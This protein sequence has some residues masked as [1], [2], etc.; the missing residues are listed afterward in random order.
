MRWLALDL[1]RRRVGAAL[2]DDREV[3]ITTLPPFRFAALLASVTAIVNEYGV[4]GIVV[5]V[6]VTRSGQGRGEARAEE[7]LARLAGLGV[8]VAREDERGTTAAAEALLREAGVPRRAWPDEVDSLAARLI[9]ESFLD[10][11]HR[12]PPHPPSPPG[13]PAGEL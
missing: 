11:R 4:G 2:C 5:G 6:P 8:A 7:A 10:R 1:G 9:L 13:E 3:V 12:P